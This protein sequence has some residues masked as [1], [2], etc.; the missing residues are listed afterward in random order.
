MKTKT[1]EQG[2]STYFYGSK[3]KT[4][5]KRTCLLF[6]RENKRIRK[7]PDGE[8]ILNLLLISDILEQIVKW[9]NKKI[10]RKELLEKS[11]Y[12]R[13]KVSY[14]HETDLIELKGFIGRLI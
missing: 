5:R 8:E 2:D 4:W 1:E 7:N 14:V 9:T 6:V 13:T 11:N 10:G 3:P 12:N